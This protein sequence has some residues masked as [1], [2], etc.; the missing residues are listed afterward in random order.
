MVSPSGMEQK[1]RWNSFVTLVGAAIGRLQPSMRNYPVLAANGRP[2]ERS[3][4]I[5][6]TP[7]SSLLTPHS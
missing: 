1:T 6:I 5:S 7:N 4:R 2:Y 3:E